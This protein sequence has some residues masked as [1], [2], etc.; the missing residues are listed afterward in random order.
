MVKTGDKISLLFAYNN[1][2]NLIIYAAIVYNYMILSETSIEEFSRRRRQ[3]I[4][5]KYPG[6]YIVRS[7]ITL[8][9]IWSNKVNF[10][11]PV[12]AFWDRELEQKK[13]RKI[14]AN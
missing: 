3:I 9:F 7:Q 5:K 10:K 12:Q 14:E 1:F 4:I 2:F 11:K 8:A 13:N 6:N